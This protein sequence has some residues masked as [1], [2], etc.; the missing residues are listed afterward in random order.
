MVEIISIKIPSYVKTVPR[1][2][3]FVKLK[4]LLFFVILK[5]NVSN[6][7]NF[8]TIANITYSKVLPCILDAWIMKNNEART[9][10]F[11]DDAEEHFQFLKDRTA[12]FR[13]APVHDYANYQG[14]W[15][16][17]I[18][19]SRYL[20]SSVYRFNGLI[21][22]F[23]QWIDNQILRRHYFDD[24]NNELRQILRPN[25]LYLAVS[26]GDIGLGKIGVSLP[27]ILV[28]SAGG[29]G[30]VPIPLIRGEIPWK[31]LPD[32]FQQM[33]GFFGSIRQ[34]SR[35]DMLS[36]IKKLSESLNVPY[37]H[38]SGCIFYPFI[39]FRLYFYSVMLIK[40]IKK[41]NE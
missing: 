17:N 38:G 34:G 16:E 37:K 26:Q 1:F 25:V 3:M 33:I 22:L 7:T 27:N 36:Q 13:T 14:P 18:F 32:G 29:F 12:R 19:I 21:P 39:F 41:I 28:L 6:Q 11:P 5:S 15:I 10:A 35:V 2:K 20:D 31:P 4:V 8:Q 23:I 40:K 30:H 9:F 24:I